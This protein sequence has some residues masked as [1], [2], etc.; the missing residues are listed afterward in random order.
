MPATASSL[1]KSKM[2]AETVGPE[3]LELLGGLSEAKQ[4]ELLDFARFLHQQATGAST[5]ADE[6]LALREVAAGSLFQLTG[7][8]SLGGDAVADAEALYDGT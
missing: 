3:L 7:L 6:S 5:E 2:P 8:V 4:F 1:A